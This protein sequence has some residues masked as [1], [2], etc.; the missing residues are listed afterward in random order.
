MGPRWK[1]G[2]FRPLK[3]N[4]LAIGKGSKHSKFGSVYDTIY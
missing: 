2:K 3:E 4:K 1:D